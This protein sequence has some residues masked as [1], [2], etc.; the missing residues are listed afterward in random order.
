MD[1]RNRHIVVTGGA[2]ALGTATV[3]QLIDAGAVCHVPCMDEAEAARFRLRD[4]RQVKLTVTGSTFAAIFR[5]ISRARATSIA[6]SGRFSGEIRP[7]KARYFPGLRWRFK[8]L[9]SNPLY[10]VP[11]Q[12]AF[13]SGLR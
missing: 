4:H 6:R 1:F 13:M 5:G 9:K 8:S 7:R 2:G 3:A 10:T 11:S 12:L